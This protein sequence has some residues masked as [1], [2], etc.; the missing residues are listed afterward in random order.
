LEPIIIKKYTDEE[1]REAR[2]KLWL[3]GE[4]SWKLDPVQKKI[5]KFLKENNQKV[6][7][8]NVSRRVGKT[9]YLTICAI[10]QC[11]KNPKSIVNFLQPEQKMIKNNVNPIM[12]EILQDCPNEVKPV[13]HVNESAWKFKNGSVIRLAG[14]DSGNQE[15]L[16]GGNSHLCIIDEAGFLK[17][18]LVHIIRRIFIPSTS[19]TKGK[20]ILSSTTPVDPNNKFMNYMES[21]EAKGA[22]FRMNIYEAVEIHKTFKNPRF[23]EAML[24]EILTEYPDGE[25]DEDFRREYM[26][27]LITD[28]SLSIIPEFTPDIQRECIAKWIRPAFCDKYVAMDI[29]FKD[30]TVVLFAYYDFENAVTVIEDEIVINGPKMTTDYLAELIKNK[31]KELWTET[32]TGEF[33]PPSL[34]VSDNNLLIINDLARLHKLYFIPTQKDNKDAA[35]NNVRM[36]MGAHK[37]IIHPKCTTLINHLKFGVWDN[38]RKDFKRSADGAHYDAIAALMYLMRN[39]NKNVNPFPRDYHFYQ[40][41]KSSTDYHKNP[42]YSKHPQEDMYLKMFNIKK[43]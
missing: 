36:E 39:I 10:E 38:Q 35:I 12:D 5:V 41:K 25:R 2:H 33:C 15:K 34:R 43:P 40:K 29:G 24:S 32:L 17:A 26:N 13:F 19:L 27:E 16:R 6:S 31:E 28:G 11:I 18:D 8:L 22:L 20:I 9:Y 7:V 21:A 4:L 37:I 42:S 1:I 30:L 14:T 3:Q 23:S